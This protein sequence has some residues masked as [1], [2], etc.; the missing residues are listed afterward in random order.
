MQADIPKTGFLVSLISYLSFWLLDA[1]RPGFVARFFSV[2]LFLLASIL[3]AIWWVRCD[4]SAV[5]HP[6]LHVVVAGVLGIVLSV[7][8]WNVGE[9]FGGLRI[10]VCLVALIMPLLIL[11][12]IKYK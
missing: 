11:R 7:L 1:L 2:H 4:V 5:D 8:M 12:L 9:G 3:F 10:L 6:R